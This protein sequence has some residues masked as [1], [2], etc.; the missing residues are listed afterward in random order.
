MLQLTD[1]LAGGNQNTVPSWDTTARV[2]TLS[3]WLCLRK[4]WSNYIDCPCTLRQR[5]KKLHWVSIEWN[6]IVTKTITSFCGHFTNIL[7]KHYVS[8]EMKYQM[9]L[10]HTMRPNRNVLLQTHLPFVTIYGL[11]CSSSKDN[12]TTMIAHGKEF[13]KTRWSYSWNSKNSAGATFLSA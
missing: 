1:I 8:G 11:L 5:R 4:K 2:S 6:S 7:K 9:T 10:F 3:G 13:D 12:E